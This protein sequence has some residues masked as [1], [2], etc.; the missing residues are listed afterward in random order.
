MLLLTGKNFQALMEESK[1]SN[2]LIYSY[3]VLIDIIFINSKF[4]VLGLQICSR[5]F[6]N[7]VTKQSKWLIPE[8]LKVFS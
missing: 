1:L 2:P 5:Y 8:E 4:D 3:I 7:K 6:Y